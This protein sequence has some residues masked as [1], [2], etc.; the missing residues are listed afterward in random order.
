M[1]ARADMQGRLVITPGHEGERPHTHSTPL[2][3]REIE[4]L[5]NL[6]PHIVS[7]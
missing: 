5:A 1:R 3:P 6:L 4:Q 7:M 2:S